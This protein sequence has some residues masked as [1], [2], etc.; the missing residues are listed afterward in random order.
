M[1]KILF[2]V[3]VGLLV[4]AC[5]GRRMSE[6]ELQQ[7][8]D[9]V[10]AVESLHQL[11]MQG[12]ALEDAN[13]LQVF[14]DSLAIQPLPLVSDISYLEEAPNYLS[15]PK[16]LALLMELDTGMVTRVISLP[17][18]ISTRLMLEMVNH[19]YEDYTLWLYSLD[20]DY[21]VVDK[22]ML[23]STRQEKQLAAKKMRVGFSITTD[24]EIRLDRYSNDNKL[25]WEGLY[26]VDE[27]RHFVKN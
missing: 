10:K 18:T 11:Q 22:M 8:I 13:P 16:E 20:V 12:I 6:A 2:L 17:E 26:K 23:Y 27:S 3:G 1:R 5:G 19:T 14:Y 9:S 21:T 24:Y 7:K 25:V 4:A 15:I